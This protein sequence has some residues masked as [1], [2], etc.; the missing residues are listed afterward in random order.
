[1]PPHYYIPTRRT[2]S[3]HTTSEINALGYDPDGRLTQV[4]QH[5]FGVWTPHVVR[6]SRF[7]GKYCAP[8]RY[9]PPTAAQFP[10]LPL[11]FVQK[12]S[13]PYYGSPRAPYLPPPLDYDSAVFSALVSRPRRGRR[14]IRGKL[15]E[16]R[17]AVVP[18][19]EG[20]TYF[21]L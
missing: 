21:N 1:M 19:A 18:I 13:P 12:M 2:I 9:G 14:H 4:I 11:G 5:L 7:S 17:A 8:P 10:W 16:E 20:G 3:R 15:V 6:H